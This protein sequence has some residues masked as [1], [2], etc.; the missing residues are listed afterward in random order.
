MYRHCLGVYHW[1]TLLLGR[2]PKVLEGDSPT[3][4]RFCQNSSELDIEE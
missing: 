2:G 3:H 4:G 1:G